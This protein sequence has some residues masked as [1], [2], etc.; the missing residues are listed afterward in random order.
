MNTMNTEQQYIRAFNN[1]Y[2]LTHYEP[3]L[4]NVI[5]KNLAQTNNYLKG[6]FAG[7]EQKE[8]E[9][10][11]EKLSEIEELRNQSN[12]RGEELSRD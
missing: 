5:S 6:F 3:K 1:G 8:F 9:Q 7:K 4:L 11:K 10:G 2:I 12:N